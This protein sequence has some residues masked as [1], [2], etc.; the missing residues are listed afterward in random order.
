MNVP[1]TID[2]L[3]EREGGSKFTNHPNDRG[4]ATRWGVTEQVA[5]AQGYTGD[6]RE[7]PVETARDIYRVRYWTGP[8][9][10][11]VHDRSPAVAEELLD[12]GVNMGP[13]VAA[14]FLQRALNVLNRGA[15]AYP[16]IL[17]DGQ[18]GHMTLFALD[19]YLAKRGGDGVTVLLRMLNGLRAVRYIEI[20][21]ANPSQESFEHGWILNRVA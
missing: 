8:N 7:L 17:V 21:E 19:Q 13:T 9:F 18:I 11:Q 10:D 4:G 5:R 12:T 6:M 3:I 15:T 14:K 2:A 16:D 20:A 1:A